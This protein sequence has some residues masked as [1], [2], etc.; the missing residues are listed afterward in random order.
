MWGCG[1]VRRSLALIVDMPLVPRISGIIQESRGR[2]CLHV[3]GPV[4]GEINENEQCKNGI[5]ISHVIT[6]VI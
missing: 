6:L 2:C 1:G 3:S 5:L 4:C